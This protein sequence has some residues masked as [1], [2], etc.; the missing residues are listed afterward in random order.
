MGSLSFNSTQHA[1]LRGYQLPFQ[2]N[3]NYVKV[4]AKKR[5]HIINE[6]LGTVLSYFP[7]TIDSYD[8]HQEVSQTIETF[9]L[10][11]H[12]HEEEE[13]GSKGR[14]GRVNATKSSTA[15]SEGSVG[16]KGSQLST[17]ALKNL[18]GQTV[19]SLQSVGS[20]V[21]HVVGNVGTFFKEKLGEHSKQTS[22]STNAP[23]PIITELRSPVVP[24]TRKSR[25]SVISRDNDEE[26]LK[27]IGEEAN[28]MLDDERPQTELVPSYTHPLPT[29]AS[30][31]SKLGD[32]LETNPLIFFVIS[33]VSVSFLKRAAKLTV[34]MDLDILLLIVWACFCIGLHTPRPMVGGID[35]SSGPPPMTPI[36]K[37][38]G[39]H[40][41]QGR[42]LIRKSMASTPDLTRNVSAGPGFGSNYAVDPSMR[43]VGTSGFG[44]GDALEDGMEE[45]PS[46]MQRFPEGAPLGSKLNCW[47][48]PD[49]ENFQVRGANYI[50]D[51]VKEASGPF[52][53]PVRATDLFLTDTCPENAGR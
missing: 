35:K 2:V 52:V 31:G 43:S 44:D 48:E 19:E 37:R 45:G 34:T 17:Q 23:P 49:S 18:S 20:A 40:N 4:L 47:S 10:L 28:L 30:P 15:T 36:G 16:T 33:V 22:R 24:Y 41:S 7:D 13:G 42:Q 21:E 25:R 3:Y 46:P 11:D 1:V 26:E 53:F 50:S 12:C 51:K 39:Q 29:F 32:L 9:L 5:K 8:L 38:A 6:I 27:E 14:S